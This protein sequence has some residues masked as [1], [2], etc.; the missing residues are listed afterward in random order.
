LSISIREIDESIR[1]A[2]SAIVCRRNNRL[3]SGFVAVASTDSVLRRFAME[4]QKLATEADFAAFGFA[5]A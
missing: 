2:S 5:I 1:L 3:T 4:K